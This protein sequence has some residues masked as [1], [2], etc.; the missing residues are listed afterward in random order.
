MN[1]AQTPKLISNMVPCMTEH[2]A[3]FEENDCKQVI[4]WASRDKS[5]RRKGDVEMISEVVGL[6]SFKNQIV[7]A[8]DLDEFK[9]YK[10]MSEEE[11]EN[12]KTKV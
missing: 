10:N 1:N 5:V 7:V 9:G 11:K 6:V 2:I 4:A 3:K 12:C 8:E